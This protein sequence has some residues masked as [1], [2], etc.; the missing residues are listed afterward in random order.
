[1]PRKTVARNNSALKAGRNRRPGSSSTSSHERAKTAA[2][3]HTERESPT[4]SPAQKRV[5][6]TRKPSSTLLDARL[7][8]FAQLR[9]KGISAVKAAVASGFKPGSASWVSRKPG[10]QKR[11]EELKGIKQKETE[12]A[13]A[14]RARKELTSG[15]IGTADEMLEIVTDVAR[16]TSQPGH[17]KLRAASE[18]LKHRQKD[19]TGLLKH[20]WSPNEIDELLRTGKAP[21]RFQQ[22]SEIESAW[23]ALATADALTW[24]TQHTKTKNPHWQEEGRPGPYEP[25]PPYDYLINLFALLEQD[26]QVLFTEKSRDMMMS[27]ACVGYFTFNAMKVPSRSVIFQ[28]QKED[29]VIE[30]IKYAKILWEQ[31]DPRLKAA[32]P[33]RKPL[34]QQPATRLDFANGSSI[35]GIPGGA[36]QIRSYHP[37]GYLNDETSFQPE[38][39]ECYNEAISAVSGKI[40]LNSSA[41]PGWYSDV[42]KDVVRN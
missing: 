41:G 31:Q 27:W 7:E 21:V 23:V 35:I 37:W 34:D 30:L 6:Q 33:L 17:I 40:V 8:E 2:S 36:D 20:G 28:T 11:I 39:G 12:R 42:R 3:N 22:Q 18:L 5:R 32:F 14:E 19:S 24:L 1:M 16:S 38:A 13:F 10:V 25:L 9:A 15:P 26:E 4:G 29:K